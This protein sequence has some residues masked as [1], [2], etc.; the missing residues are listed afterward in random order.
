MA[1]HHDDV[2]GYQTVR[3][4][5]PGTPVA[6]LADGEAWQARALYPRI[7]FVGAVF[8]VAQE[9]EEGGWELHPYFGASAPQ[10]ARDSMGAHFRRLSQVA[11]QTGDQAAHEECMR[12]AERMEW[13][14]IDD[15]TLLGTRYRVVRAEQFIRFGETGPEPPRPTDPD[16]GEPDEARKIPDPA[17]GFVI[18]PAAP[19]GPSDGMLKLD[20]LE[21]LPRESIVPREVHDDAERAV[22]THP[23]GVLLPPAFMVGEQVAGQ[24]GAGPAEPSTT[25]Q[26]ARDALAG[27]LRIMAPWQLDLDPEQRA[28]YD[29]AAD[30]MNEERADEITVAGRRFRIVRVERLVRI[31]PDGP[32]GS[33]PSDPDPQP[34]VKVHDQQLREQ[35]LIRDDEDENK[36]IEL[37]HDAKRFGQIFYEEEERRKARIAKRS[38]RGTASS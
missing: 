17:T 14:A 4:T 20:L 31:G 8:G 37:S 16:P 35:G 21:L 19:T 36:P 25:P 15:A 32:E 27:Y 26:G 38:A 34:P 6:E 2:P 11:G 3:I 13:E 18:D 23:G 22:R 29:A 28:V 33:R 7:A 9:R 10:D 24:W 5:E 1:G 30:R 12:A